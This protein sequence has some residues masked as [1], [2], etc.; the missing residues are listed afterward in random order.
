MSE[1]REERA[2][3][4][5]EERGVG[6]GRGSE[7]IGGYGRGSAYKFAKTFNPNNFRN[8]VNFK[9]AIKIF[10]IISFLTMAY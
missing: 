2:P 10:N 7:G 9:T 4:R 8:F 5:R 3:S 1:Y 6:G